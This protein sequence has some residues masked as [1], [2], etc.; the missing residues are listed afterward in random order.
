MIEQEGRFAKAFA[1]RL[2]GLDDRAN[3]LVKP[4]EE[5]D[6]N[7]FSFLPFP[8]TP[9]DPQLSEPIRMK[10][11]SQQGLVRAQLR[12]I[13]FTSR[14]VTPGSIAYAE[15]LSAPTRKKLFSSMRPTGTPMVHISSEETGGRDLST[16]SPDARL[17]VQLNRY[18]PDIHLWMRK[19]RPQLIPGKDFVRAREALPF[20]FTERL[21]KRL[22]AKAPNLAST[23]R[24]A[25]P[26]RRLLGQAVGGVY[27]GAPD[28][29]WLDIERRPDGS[30]AI[31]ARPRATTMPE[32][33]SHAIG[34]V[35]PLMA[36]RGVSFLPK[37]ATRAIPRTVAGRY[38][39]GAL[40]EAV[41][42]GGLEAIRGAPG[43]GVG[44]AI[45]RGAGGVITGAMFGAAHEVLAPVRAF[46]LYSRIPASV[47]TSIL[48]GLTMSGVGT[49]QTAV[50]VV[51]NPK[52]TVGEKVQALKDA[53]TEGLVVGSALA[54]PGIPEARRIQSRIRL[55]PLRQMQLEIGRGLPLVTRR[56]TETAAAS[57]ERAG[58]LRAESERTRRQYERERQVTEGQAAIQ[59]TEVPQAAEPTATGEGSR[60]NNVFDAI[61]SRRMPATEAQARELL[62]DAIG[63]QDNPGSAVAVKRGGMAD[64]L[65]EFIAELKEGFPLT[66]GETVRLPDSPIRGRVAEIRGDR[67]K[68]SVSGLAGERIVEVNVNDIFRGSRRARPAVAPAPERRVEPRVSIE[69]DALI[70]E[71]LSELGEPTPP[72]G[73][74]RLKAILATHPN[75]ERMSAA[76]IETVLTEAN[77]VFAGDLPIPDEIWDWANRV[78]ERRQELSRA[79]LRERRTAGVSPAEPLRSSIDDLLDEIMAMPARET[80]V[81]LLRPIADRMMEREPQRFERWGQAADTLV[82]A[83]M[84][85][86]PSLSRNAAITA[87]AGRAG[88]EAPERTGEPPPERSAIRPPEEEAP[89]PVRKAPT[90]EEELRMVQAQLDEARTDLGRV[91]DDPAAKGT[92]SK[93]IDDLQAREKELHDELGREEAGRDMPD[94]LVERADELQALR[95]PDIFRKV[96]GQDAQGRQR[97]GP[98]VAGYYIGKADAPLRAFLNGL[99]DLS[100]TRDNRY[101]QVRGTA[102]PITTGQVVVEGEI[103]G[104]YVPAPAVDRGLQRFRVSARRGQIPQMR[105]FGMP[106][107]AAGYGEFEP[108]RGLIDRL[109]SDPRARGATPQQIGNALV[110]RYLAQPGKQGQ[111][112]GQ[113]IAVLARGVTLPVGGAPRAQPT[114]GPSV[115]REAPPAGGR[116]PAAEP[117]A[118]GGGR[119]PPVQPTAAGSTGRGQETS[120]AIARTAAANFVLAR[121]N[122]VPKPTLTL[123]QDILDGISSSTRTNAQSL[124][125]DRASELPNGRELMP[126]QIEAVDAALSRFASVPDSGFVVAGQPG[127]GKT[128]IGVTVMDVIRRKDPNSAIVLVVPNDTVQKNAWDSELKLWGIPSQ[129]LSASETLIG[130]TFDPNQVYWM[131]YHAL[132]AAHKAMHGSPH[133]A[134]FFG[135]PEDK[136]GLI[137]FD[138]SHKMKN[139]YQQNVNVAT[140]AHNLGMTAKRRLLLSATPFEHPLHLMYAARLVGFPFEGY[141]R[142]AGIHRDKEGNWIAPPEALNALSERLTREGLMIRHLYNYP[143]KLENGRDIQLTVEAELKGLGASEWVPMYHRARRVLST[144]VDEFQNQGKTMGANLAK[145]TWSRV[146]RRIKEMI[147]IEP[148]VIAADDAVKQGKQ[149]VV[150][151]SYIT[152]EDPQARLAA[153]DPGQKPY[154]TRINKALIDAKISTGAGPIEALFERFGD[155]GYGRDDIAEISGRL[156]DSERV[157]QLADFQAGRKKIALVSMDSGA[158]S[159]SYHD[160]AGKAPRE[161]IILT[162]PWTAMRTDQVVNRV[163]RLGSQSDAT[164]RFMLLDLPTE[165][166]YGGRVLSRLKAMNALLGSRAEAL[167][168]EDPGKALS[169]WIDDVEEGGST[170][171]MMYRVRAERDRAEQSVE[172]P[173]MAAGAPPVA[174]GVVGLAPAPAPVAPP[175]AAGAPTTAARPETVMGPAQI[176]REA[177]DR[178]NLPPVRI[179]R[180]RVLRKALGYFSPAWYGVGIR[181]KELVKLDVHAHEAM[182]HALFQRLYGKDIEAWERSLQPDQRTELEQ[183]GKA[184]YG[185]NE[186]PNGYAHEGFAEFMRLELVYGNAAQVA[187][188][189][190]AHVIIDELPKYPDIEAITSWYRNAA[191]AWMHTD[192]T[193]QLHAQVNWRTGL[194]GSGQLAEGWTG[195]KGLER[196]LSLYKFYM[197]NDRYALEEFGQDMERIMGRKLEWD[198]NPAQILKALAG[199]SRGQ[200]WLAM[201][202]GTI[203]PR[204]GLRSGESFNEIMEDVGGDIWTKRNFLVYVASRRIQEDPQQ[205]N[206]PWERATVDRNVA[207]MQVAHPEWEGYAKR[208]D[209]FFDRVFEYMLE[210]AEFP[211]DQWQAMKKNNPFYIPFYKLHM[212][213]A[214]ANNSTLGRRLVNV[215]LRTVKR[216]TGTGRPFDDFMWNIL[217]YV[218]NTFAAANKIAVVNA[219]A[220][221]AEHAAVDPTIREGPGRW[222]WRQ[223]IPPRA[224]QLTLGRVAKEMEK[225]GLDIDLQGKDPA[226]IMSFFMNMGPD[227]MKAILGDYAKE[228]AAIIYRKGE[229]QVWQFHPHLY[230]TLSDMEP[231]LIGSI[232]RLMSY[233]TRVAKLGMVSLFPDFIVKETMR[234]AAESTIRTK[235][236]AAGYMLRLPQGLKDSVGMRFGTAA[237]TRATQQFRAMGLDYTTFI[238]MDV[239]TMLRAYDKIMGREKWGK[240]RIIETPIQFTEAMLSTPE[241]APRLAEFK[242]V[243]ERAEREGWD[244][245]RALI[246]GSAAARDVAIDFMRGGKA[247]KAWSQIAPFFNA[248]VQGF[249]QNRHLLTDKDRR[250]EVAL[251]ALTLLTLPTAWWWAA[252]HKKKWYKDLNGFAK[253]GFWVFDGGDEDSGELFAIPRPREWGYFFSAVPQA[254]LDAYKEKDPV[255]AEQ[256]AR[257]LI[258]HIPITH[259]N[260]LQWHSTLPPLLLSLHE[261]SRNWS[262]FRNAPL[263]PKGKEFGPASLRY[264]P[265]RTT[266]IAK[267]IGE[268]TGYSPAVI[269]HVIRGLTGSLGLQ[270]IVLADRAAAKAGLVEPEKAKVPLMKDTPVVGAFYVSPYQQTFWTRRYY[271]KSRPIREEQNKFEHW[272]L[273]RGNVAQ[274][275][276]HHVARETIEAIKLTDETLRFGNALLREA[277][278]AKEIAAVERLMN[279]RA[280]EGLAALGERVPQ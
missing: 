43:R 132:G 30:E 227:W 203:D 79:E 56:I 269:E 16:L 140:G 185:P 26:M 159:L 45:E 177:N 139:Y 160:I 118:A 157:V 58:R 29:F 23:F 8:G 131:T 82:K 11:R 15:T 117:P 166:H 273:E 92:L 216:Y 205:R 64:D 85:K 222:A 48:S 228:N 32:K 234:Q 262:Y 163:F 197:T 213:S 78:Q 2:A 72:A 69:I 252:N 142:T 28:T 113:A 121:A 239:P 127:T 277:K 263:Y 183:L 170:G 259:G 67:I 189:V 126:H 207:D 99:F 209:G 174:A 148:T 12:K 103:T 231:D 168:K 215:G 88:I 40:K 245:K 271:D 247:V 244:P 194:F 50:A 233:L 10:L 13:P 179:G 278:T 217:T 210:W 49:A 272:T 184:L 44:G 53:V 199:S 237:G 76:D 212:E 37:M 81:D 66:V 38:A 105:L 144:V 232:P 146:A 47:S 9:I 268:K 137:V 90:P 235:G 128:V 6:F 123:T 145:A 1:Y 51:R 129:R 138:E 275:E 165:I 195:K 31:V 251:R 178:L 241:L 214:A 164:V 102:G 111:S 4:G 7:R 162:T 27:G 70:D 35:G 240:L 41:P 115:P 161:A 114:E 230:R 107:T 87:I 224:L 61:M 22:E 106:E 188:R 84:A 218:Q 73:I 21:A 68:V 46:F 220:N 125:I 110:S 75:P 242:A 182:G 260:L 112:R 91:S 42:F 238:G 71:T 255:A 93:L 83:Y 191:Q 101:R 200:A 52:M 120:G 175:P 149:V 187:P 98:P 25:D 167:A 108:L 17:L 206:S 62:R 219:L 133:L 181:S 95:E 274:A 267:S 266:E 186:P 20:V 211:V 77:L 130:K 223:E 143:L 3:E 94:E 169:D 204:T 180:A 254:A 264:A 246:E 18:I 36:T 116:L 141:A 190:Y 80:S 39:L 97:L 248:R 150:F 261:G 100:K 221:A 280:R 34:T 156:K 225:L 196:A 134:R 65:N 250:L 192:P 193:A 172:F 155:L 89:P 256:A 136:I 152:G 208:V 173:D 236:T 74:D 63:I 122:I 57:A 54:V 253:Y 24:H 55:R 153:T 249:E 119:Q 86:N 158:E 151:T 258:S 276:R 147:K 19:D 124:Q 60:W 198:E 201:A 229:W 176:M 202:A 270:A 243:M 154:A 5:T 14:Q 33:I 265:G 104:E 135:L 279:Q 109:L 59:R 257:E 226:T 96:I 171:E